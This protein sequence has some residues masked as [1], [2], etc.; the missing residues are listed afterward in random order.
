[1]HDLIKN[2][3]L[4]PP[5]IESQPDRFEK[6]CT[7]NF[8]RLSYALKDVLSIP[9]YTVST[10]PSATNYGI[11]QVTDEMDGSVLAF[12]DGSNW[13]RVTDRNVVS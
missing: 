13:R 10:L 7:E 2:L 8:L 9:A 4:T 12:S 1:M 5:D 6:W 11:I 3:D